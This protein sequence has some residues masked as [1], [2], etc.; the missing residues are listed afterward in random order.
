[1]NRHLEKKQE[2]VKIERVENKNS[3]QL[4]EKNK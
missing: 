3:I 2:I 4:Y 1:M